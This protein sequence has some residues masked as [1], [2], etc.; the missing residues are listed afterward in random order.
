MK[1]S[2]ILRAVKLYRPAMFL[3]NLLLNWAITTKFLIY[4]RK[5]RQFRKSA[6]SIVFHPSILVIM[7]RGGIG[8]LIESTP[9]VHAIRMFW[10]HADITVLAQQN[11][12][13]SQW[14]TPDHIYHS[15]DQIKGLSFDHTF[16]AYWEWKNIPKN[17]YSCELGQ[18][19]YPKIWFNK[20]F[21][22]PEKLYYLD[23]IKSLGYRG[24]C[25]GLYVSQKEPSSTPP[26][27][28]LRICLVPGGINV[29]MWRHKHW[30]FYDKLARLILD[31]YPQAQICIIGTLQDNIPG[32]LPIDKR[33]VDLRGSLSL[34]E[35]AWILKHSTL[36]I[37]N[38]CGP[39]HIADA[40]QTISIR[41]FGPTCPLK[42]APHYKT[43]SVFAKLPC[44]PCQ[45]T[46]QLTTCPEAECM[47]SITP[48]MI[49][50]KV[51][52]LL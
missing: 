9:L 40:V 45:Y 49:M 11:D 21:L 28:D 3:K 13:F 8:N 41:I 44:Q 33:I 7:N 10:P 29:Q 31:E 19:H 12:L 36:A 23:M 6:N 48:D 1:I 47:T 52:K 22:K 37:G 42:N 17:K 26:P 43:I 38:D 2:T 14:C 27:T 25:P 20:P 35:S 15:E 32:E 50:Q 5:L 51:K 46:D 16:M 24:Q 34:A 4:Q 30:P 18:I 39:M